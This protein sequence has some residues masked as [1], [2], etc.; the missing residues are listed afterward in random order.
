[1]A[2]GPGGGGHSGSQ[3]CEP[4]MSAHLVLSR[5]AAASVVGS[6]G[7]AS[8]SVSEPCE[9]VQIIRF[10]GSQGKFPFGSRAEHG[11]VQRIGQARK[12]WIR[13]LRI[14]DTG[15]RLRYL[16]Q[17]FSEEKRIRC[18]L[19]RRRRTKALGLPFMI[20]SVCKVGYSKLRFFV[21]D[22]RCSI[23][24]TICIDKCNESVRMV[25]DQL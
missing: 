10:S 18:P 8:L 24:Y 12:R 16:Q 1:M 4:A 15:I 7:G 25:R 3:L 19:D 2:V 23:R 22:M 17:P 20:V 6:A 14:Q 13:G 9:Q 5:C 11:R 21:G